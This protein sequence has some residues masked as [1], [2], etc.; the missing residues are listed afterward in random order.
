MDINQIHNWINFITNKAQGSYYSIEEIDMALDRA[1]MTYFNETY[2]QYSLAE[3]IDDSLSPFKTKYSFLTSDTTSGLV[4]LPTNYLY[5]TG[6]HIS[7]VDHGNAKSRPLKVLTE[8]ELSYRLN[9]Q[10]RPVTN[11]TPVC[12][13][14]GKSAG[15][16]LLQLFPAVAMA[17]TIY[18]LRRP[19][20]PA[21]GYTQSGRTITYNS[22]TS[23]Q[24]EWNES[25]IMEI[26]IRAIESLGI[27]IDDQQ[28]IEYADAKT[29][30]VN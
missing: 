10:L 7:V 3:K 19:A 17:G 28:M 15:S 30:E 11:N 4:T 22:G 9:S 23:T 29:K 5:M 27:S 14:A 18:Y 6:G 2:A 21:M 24:L 13:I 25:E 8:D 26:M 1:Q 12:I 20:V 16:T